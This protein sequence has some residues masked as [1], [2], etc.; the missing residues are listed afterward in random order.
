MMHVFRRVPPY[1]ELHVRRMRDDDVAL[2]E[3]MMNQT[4]WAFLSVTPDEIPL[5][6]AD[7][8]SLIAEAQ[9]K[10]WASVL[11]SWSHQPSVWIRGIV[12]HHSL[13]LRDVLPQFLHACIQHCACQQARTIYIMLDPRD[14]HWFHAPLSDVGFEH[15][16]DVVGY[17][18]RSF[19]IPSWGNTRIAVRPATHADIA[20]IAHVDAQAFPSEWV[21]SAAILSGVMPYA[22][23]YLVAEDAGT[24]IGYAFAT[25]HHSGRM[26]HLVRIAVLPHYQHHGVGVRLMAEVVAWCQEHKTQVLSLNTQNDNLHAQRLY[27]WFGFV[28]NNECQMVL[29]KELGIRK[30][31][32]NIKNPDS[33]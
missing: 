2:V 28:R 32:F 33:R 17:E 16:L 14:Q 24:M 29:R 18:K 13:R 10:I 26:M 8:L 25:S 15:T 30:A 5:M 9:G 3:A 11:A 22:P 31:K 12:I 4:T 23:L 7:G 21:K 1:S 19:E 27:Q 20:A 6:L